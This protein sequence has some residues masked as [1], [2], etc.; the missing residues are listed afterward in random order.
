MYQLLGAEVRNVDLLTIIA[1]SNGVNSLD[2][3]VVS[4]EIPAARVK[5]FDST[6]LPATQKWPASRGRHS[7]IG[8]FKQH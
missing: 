5:T 2:T 6:W 8:A 3:Y 4:L 1:E 7:R